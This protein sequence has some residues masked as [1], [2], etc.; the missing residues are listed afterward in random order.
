MQKELEKIQ[1]KLEWNYRGH[2][3]CEETKMTEQLK[4][5]NSQKTVDKGHNFEIYKIMKRYVQN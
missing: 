4:R 2:G 1:T 5:L 3:T